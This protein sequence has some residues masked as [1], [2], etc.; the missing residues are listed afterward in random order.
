M[1]PKYAIAGIP[2]V[3]ARARFFAPSSSSFSVHHR[4]SNADQLAAKGFETRVVHS[5]IMK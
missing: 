3:G 5:S 2:L 4:L 1:P